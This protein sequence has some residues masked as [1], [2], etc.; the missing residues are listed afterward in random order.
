VEIA[1]GLAQAVVVA[2]PC[3]EGAALAVPDLDLIEAGIIVVAAKIELDEV[4]FV[5]LTGKLQSLLRRLGFEVAEGIVRGGE[6][7]GSVSLGLRGIPLFVCL[8]EKKKGQPDRPPLRYW[9]NAPG[10]TG[11]RLRDP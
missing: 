8:A 10:T 4:V 5:E 11:A 9:I 3:S 2:Y 1:R 6:I 7:F